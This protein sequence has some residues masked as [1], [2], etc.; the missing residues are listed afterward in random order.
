MV[1]QMGCSGGSSHP[2]RERVLPSAGMSLRGVRL[3]VQAERS[4]A[5]TVVW[6]CARCALAAKRRNHGPSLYSCTRGPGSACRLGAMDVPG[7]ATKRTP[8]VRTRGEKRPLC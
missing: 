7:C 6:I 2:G 3:G 1:S 5:R 8:H 4:T